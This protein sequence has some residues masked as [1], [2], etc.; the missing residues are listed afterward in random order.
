MAIV[1]DADGKETVG[2]I[3]AIRNAFVEASGGK[4][5]CTDARMGYD[6]THGANGQ[7]LTFIGRWGDG[8]AFEVSHYVP[9]HAPLAP[10]ARAAAR[11]I[12]EGRKG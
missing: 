5:T 2:G 1:I 9:P 6:H 12:I 7:R 8:T 3:V 10:H 11:E 4:L